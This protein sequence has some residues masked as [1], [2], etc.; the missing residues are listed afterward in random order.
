MRRKLTAEYGGCQICKKVTPYAENA[1]DTQESLV[2]IAKSRGSP[3]Y[4]GTIDTSRP[5]GNQIWLCPRHRALYERR[6]VRF[7]VLEDAFGGEHQWGR[8]RIPDNA[9]SRGISELEKTRDA[10]EEGEDLKVRIFDQEIS[11]GGIYDIDVKP[12]WNEKSLN[13][14]SEHGKAILTK[15]IDILKNTNS[16]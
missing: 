6:L 3:Y 2:S 14:T 1:H 15:L 10:W 9:F 13:V 7:T 11:W 4:V 16:D 8:S 5:L 12:S